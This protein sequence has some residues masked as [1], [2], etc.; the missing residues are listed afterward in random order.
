[1]RQVGEFL[2]ALERVAGGGAAFDPEVL[3]RLLARTTRADPLARLTAR[4][5][6]V[7]AEMAEGHTNRAS[8][9]SS[10]FRRV[11]RKST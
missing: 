11:R 3:R 2:D 7:V 1:M 8:A 6:E 4:E 5:H 9:P 10:T